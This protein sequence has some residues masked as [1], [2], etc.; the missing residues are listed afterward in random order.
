MKRTALSLLAVALAFAA[1]PTL[2]AQGHAAPAGMGAAQSASKIDGEVRKIDKA[3]GKVTIKHG[4]IKQMGMPPMTMM[5]ATKDKAML[6]K[7]KVGD[8]IRFSLASEGSSIVV[9]EIEPA[10]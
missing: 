8:K 6:D 4:E 7:V 10:K 9:T 5:F 1:S 2:H 3:S